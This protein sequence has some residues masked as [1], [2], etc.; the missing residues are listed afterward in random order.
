MFSENDETRL[1][2]ERGCWTDSLSFEECAINYWWS[3]SEEEAKGQ[4][5]ECR[6]WETEVRKLLEKMFVV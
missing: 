2:R 5:N 4:K 6:G 1:R 3:G